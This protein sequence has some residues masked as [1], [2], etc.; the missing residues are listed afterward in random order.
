MT[1]SDKMNA[2]IR[3]QAGVTPAQLRPT[4]PYASEDVSA[5]FA[6]TPRPTTNA[7]YGVG[8]PR[9]PIKQ[10][11]SARMNNLIRKAAAK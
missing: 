7:G 5:P 10:S 11:T 2:W 3:Q 8:A 1:T 9:V 4:G 6:F